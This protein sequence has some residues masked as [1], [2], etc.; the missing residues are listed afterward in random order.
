MNFPRDYTLGQMERYGHCGVLAVAVV[1]GKSF[2]QT[3]AILGGIT[4]S[5]VSH[6]K[7]WRGSTYDHELKLALKKFGVK[8]VSQSFYSP[9]RVTVRRFAEMHAKPNRLY[10]VTTYDHVACVRDGVVLDTYGRAAAFEHPVKMKRIE[11]V[12]EIL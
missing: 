5:R 3:W 4:S 11:S 12:L 9:E 7:M 6:R 8:Y 1:S 2:A 10:M